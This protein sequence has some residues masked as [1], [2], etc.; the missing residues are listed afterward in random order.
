MSSVP[1]TRKSV[2]LTRP[3]SSSG[4]PSLASSGFAF[5][6]AVQ[7]SVAVGIRS[8]S[9]SVAASASSEVERVRDADLDPAPDEL[10]GSVLAEPP[11]ISCRIEGA[12][13]T[14][15]HRCFASRSRG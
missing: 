3:R 12:A 11:G 8:P 13:S 14:S 2:H 7:T 4:R 10:P 9:E 1:S 15:T 5:T 6:P